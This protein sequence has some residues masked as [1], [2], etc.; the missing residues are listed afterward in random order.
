M[1]FKVI[2]ITTMVKKHTSPNGDLVNLT[3]GKEQR[4]GNFM[5]NA[6]HRNYYVDVERLDKVTLYSELF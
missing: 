3:G 5:W 1:L 6:C 4:D 2:E